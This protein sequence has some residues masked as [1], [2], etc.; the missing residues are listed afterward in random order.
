[1]FL[2]SIKTDTQNND[3]IGACGPPGRSTS[4][5]PRD[6]GGPPRVARVFAVDLKG[7]KCSNSFMFAQD[8][9]RRLL[10]LLAR[11][12]R[13]TVREIETALAASPATVR[14]D[15]ADL[16]RTGGLVRTH[17]G[18]IH[19]AALQGEPALQQRARVSMRAK[20]AVA[21]RAAAHVPANATVYLDAGSTALAVARRL[22]ARRDVTLFTNSLPVLLM[23]R[24]G[25]ARVV[26]P[27]GEVRVPSQ[28]LVGS[29]ALDW[30]K[31]LRFDVAF[32][33]ASGLEARDGASV[34][35]LEEAAMKQAALA[36]ASRAILV[37]DAAKWRRPAAVR[38]A[39]WN[40][41]DRWITDRR[42]P[43][44]AARAIAAAGVTV[45]IAR[46]RAR[47]EP[48]AGDGGADREGE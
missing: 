38:F 10:D 16:A 47:A 7:A 43:A 3:M 42:P 30:L 34:T 36:R 12:S 11:R 40:A 39:G 18:V 19:P 44:A 5:T 20:E 23:A 2:A 37:A 45:E 27:G 13:L 24:A 46:D 31:H 8:R 32:I 14:R 22:V 48:G 35:S 9:R 29:L 1:V 15:L 33:G 4:T 21:E 17:G 41:F 26:A 6:A 25:G 28:S